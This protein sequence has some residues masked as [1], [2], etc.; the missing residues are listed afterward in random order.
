MKQ[1][2]ALLNDTKQLLE[3]RKIIDE[4]L[5]DADKQKL[6]TYAVYK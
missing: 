3:I 6:K 4:Q 5:K 2:R 1:N